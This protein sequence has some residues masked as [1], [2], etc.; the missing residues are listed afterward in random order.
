MQRS[1]SPGKRQF[2]R[3]IWRVTL[4]QEG[5][6][7]DQSPSCLLQLEAQLSAHLDIVLNGL[8]ECAH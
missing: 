8:S 1:L 3:D 5:G 4:L 6:E 2:R 7:V